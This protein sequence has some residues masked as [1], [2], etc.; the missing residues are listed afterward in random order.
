LRAKFEEFGHVEE[1]VCIHCRLAKSPAKL[2]R[3]AS[4][5]VVKDRDTGRSRGFGF[6]RFADEAD[7]DSAV[8]ISSS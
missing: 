8:N 4:K 6:V 5:V 7:A 3:I 1:A 2:I